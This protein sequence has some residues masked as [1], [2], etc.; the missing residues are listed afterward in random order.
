MFW[1]TQIN[2]GRQMVADTVT[3]PKIPKEAAAEFPFQV[4]QDGFGLVIYTKDYDEP[5]AVPVRDESGSIAP[6][7]ICCSTLKNDSDEPLT[8]FK[9]LPSMR[10]KVPYM[11]GGETPTVGQEV[12]ANFLNVRALE[13]EEPTQGH[14]I[15]EDVDPL[16]KTYKLT[17]MGDTIDVLDVIVR[18][19]PPVTVTSGD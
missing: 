14:I 18:I 16:D 8:A 7:Y 10:F 1:L 4:Y 13:E 12:A 15:I 6:Q 2:N 11:L 19:Y 5:A 9:V 17:F 3:L